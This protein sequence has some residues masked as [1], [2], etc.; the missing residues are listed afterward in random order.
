MCYHH[1]LDQHR[2]V[3]ESDCNS[4]AF[5]RFA[6]HVILLDW[7]LDEGAPNAAGGNYLST[8]LPPSMILVV[9]SFLFARQC[10]APTLLRMKKNLLQPKL[11]LYLPEALL[12]ASA[13]QPTIALDPYV[14]VLED[15]I[16]MFNVD[17]RAICH[18]PK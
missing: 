12:L 11:L 6:T 17:E 1:V 7:Y 8:F 13:S 2:F 9:D 18:W 14:G 3:P 5:R 4:K 15:A 16:E 10:G